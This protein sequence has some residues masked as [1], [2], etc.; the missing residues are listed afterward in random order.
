MDYIVQGE[1]RFYIEDFTTR[2]LHRNH[3]REHHKPNTQ[4]TNPHSYKLGKGH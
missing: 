1:T 4:N 2:P 3:S